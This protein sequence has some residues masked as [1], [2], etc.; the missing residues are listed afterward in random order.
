MASMTKLYHHS[1]YPAIS[2]ENPSNDQ[3]GRTVAITGGATGIGYAT[4]KAFVQA[5]A[6]KVIILGRQLEK[7]QNA[8]EKLKKEVGSTSTHILCR[9]CD[10]NSDSSIEHFWR[11]LA[12]DRILVDVLVL[13]ATDPA[14]GL[15]TPLL[16]CIPNL[17]RAF[18]ANVSANTM[19]AG[20]F[21]DA[22]NETQKQ[23]VLLNIS[24]ASVHCNPAPGQA[25]Y[26]SSKAAFASL[27]QH[28]AEEIPVD[29]CQ[30]INIHPGVI[31]TP[32]AEAVSHPDFVK[33]AVYDQG[34]LNRP[35]PSCHSLRRNDLGFAALTLSLSVSTSIA[36]VR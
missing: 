21:L 15:V 19:M 13:N 18:N 35:L 5:N 8:C 9:V 22:P 29:Q 16:K 6:S 1:P 28:A 34:E 10:I 12:G 36:T 25:M 7:L 31:R 30:I 11:T 23:K 32:G 2:P 17:K 14:G 3:K 33:I 24:T 26:S 27:L 4:A 20:H